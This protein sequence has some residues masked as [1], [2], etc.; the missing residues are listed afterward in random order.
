NLLD[1]SS[2]WDPTKPWCE[3]AE[4]NRACDQMLRNPKVDVPALITRMAHDFPLTCQLLFTTHDPRR[5]PSHMPFKLWDYQVKM[6]KCFT[7]C[8]DNL[9]SMLMEKTRDVGASWVFCAWLLWQWIFSDDFQALFTTRKK[10]MVDSRDEPDTMFERLRQMLTRM[11]D[12]FKA[13]LLPDYNP[14]RHATFAKLLNPRSGSTITG[15]PPVDTFARQG[16]Y[17]VIIY[18]EAAYMARLRT[19]MASAGD[20]SECHIYIS[21]PNGMSGPY[22]EMRNAGRIPVVTVHWS[23]HPLKSRGMYLP[24]QAAAQDGFAELAKRMEQR[25]EQ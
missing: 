21:T 23:V 4:R 20:S 9:M 17:G 2:N 1:T 5:R 15:E 7:Y 11:P 14:A 3:V 16:R 22:Y 12:G 18:D 8:Y 24:E 10:E 13:L 25:N 19:M 6:G